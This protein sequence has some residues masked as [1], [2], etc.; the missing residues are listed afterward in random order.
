MSCPGKR[1]SPAECANLLERDYM[2]YLTFENSKCKDY[3]TEKFFAIQQLDIVPIVMGG[4]NYS[5]IAPRDSYI[6]VN[7]YSSA[8]E[9][10]EELKRLSNAREEYLNFFRWKAETEVLDGYGRMGCNLC[11]AL[12]EARP[13]KTYQDMGAWWSDGENCH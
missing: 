1:T 12:H 2:F 7:D 10:A 3:V 9:L 5:A 11:K 4:A 6:D 13:T 8:R